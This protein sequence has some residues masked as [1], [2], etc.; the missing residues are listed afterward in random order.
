MVVHT[1]PASTAGTV[2]AAPYVLPAPH[3]RKNVAPS[4]KNATQTALTLRKKSVTG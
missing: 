1:M 3:P 4:V 2:P